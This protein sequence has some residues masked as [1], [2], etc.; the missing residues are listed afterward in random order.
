MS[1]PP[2]AL[3]NIKINQFLI[4]RQED[5]NLVADV[6]NYCCGNIREASAASLMARRPEIKHKIA[7]EL[8]IAF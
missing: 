8:F 1:A 3:L 7:S 4:M 6:R 5:I 2:F